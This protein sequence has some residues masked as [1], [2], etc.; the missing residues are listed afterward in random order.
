[1]AKTIDPEALHQK[2]TPLVQEILANTPPEKLMAEL[3]GFGVDC[4]HAGRTAER[5]YWGN[6]FAEMAAEATLP[7]FYEPE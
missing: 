1:M 3:V 6:R 7:V 5:G 2:I 4:Y